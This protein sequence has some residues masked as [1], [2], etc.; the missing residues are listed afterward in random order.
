M[1]KMKRLKNYGL[2]TALLGSMTLTS[3]LGDGNN[4][5]QG[6][7]CGVIDLNMSV[8]A[9]G[10][11]VDD[12]QPML[13]ST[14]FS[15]MSPGDCV[16]FYATIDYDAQTN[17]N[18]IAATVSQCEKLDKYT[19]VAYL[20]TANLRP[21]EMTIS[22]VGL[23][24]S[25]VKGHMFVNTAHPYVSTDQKIDYWMMYDLNKKPASDGNDLYEIW[26]RAQNIRAGEKVAAPG[27]L[28][29]A[30][31]ASA[32]VS[33]TTAVERAAGK[34]KVYFRFRYPSAFNNDTTIVTEWRASQTY[35]FQIPPQS[36]NQQ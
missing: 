2:A 34:D 18:Y 23:P 24:W 6:L 1:R 13:Y 4:T 11:Y 26:L 7:M 17:N 32:F 20:D 28:L 22:D 21:G 16:I 19:A 36:S 29:N 10:A 5:Q 25:M 35:Y 8:G 31:D 9:Y 12:D 27:T 15:A 33:Q 14:A 3:C 30:F